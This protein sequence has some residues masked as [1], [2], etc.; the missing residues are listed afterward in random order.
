MMLGCNIGVKNLPSCLKIDF[1]SQLILFSWSSEFARCSKASG[2]TPYLE[3]KLNCRLVRRPDSSNFER[4][5]L[6]GSNQKC[7][8]S[9]MISSKERWPSSPVEVVVSA[10]RW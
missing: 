5:R 4:P 1:R 6:S 3:N 9:R 7:Q 10:L 2:N 8:Y